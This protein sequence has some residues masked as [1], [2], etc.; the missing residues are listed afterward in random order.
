MK[1]RIIAVVLTVVAG[2]AGWAAVATEGDRQGG[3][4]VAEFT[5]ASPLLLGSDVKVDG[6]TVGKIVDMRVGRHNRARV[7]MKL[8]QEAFPVHRDATATVRAVS[9]LGERYVDLKRGSDAAPALPDGGTLPRSQTGQ[10]TDLDEVLNTI[11]QPTGEALA[12]LVAAL[13]EGMDGHGADA[14]QVIAALE[15]ALRDVDGLAKILG[16]QNG[17]LL[18]LLDK[19]E[20]VAGALA[21]DGGKTLDGLVRSTKTL[22]SV[23]A[24]RRKELEAT[25]TKLPALFTEANRALGELS[26]TARQTTPV[27]RSLR[28]VTGDLSE[29]SRELR[30]FTAA[31]NPALASTEPVLDKAKQLLDR[32][33]PI[34]E[35]LRKAGPNLRTSLAGARPVVDELADDM[36]TVMTFI[37]Q[38]ALTTNG[39]D[40]VSHYF[41]G[42]VTFDAGIAANHL[43]PQLL[44]DGAPKVP[45]LNQPPPDER[46]GGGLVP[47]VPGGLLGPSTKDGGATGLE[48]EQETGLLD[49]LLGGG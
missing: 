7:A 44:G 19:L 42:H 34:A 26:G 1:A 46:P 18:S 12:A 24:A 22:T 13:G 3:V 23:T 43:L 33:R 11:D 41:R 48:P 32:A 9:L 37:R 31:A 4:I 29:I 2:T 20:P 45:P 30:R 28:P 27:L 39:Y 40:G 36:D 10:N 17:T 14:A 5:S 8:D 47:G 38:W 6:V 15:P 49:Y 25:L 35:E 16:E 21:D